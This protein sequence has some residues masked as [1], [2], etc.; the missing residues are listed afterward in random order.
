MPNQQAKTT[1]CMFTVEPA[2]TFPNI[3]LTPA[4]KSN[5]SPRFQSGIFVGTVTTFESPS[6]KKKAGTRTRNPAIGPA[7]PISKR[8]ARLGNGSRMRISA[9]SVPVRMIGIGM[10]Y[11]SDASTLYLRHIT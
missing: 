1:G 6:P 8:A 5:G 2:V 4:L 9:P 3:N 11:G 7:T 10:K